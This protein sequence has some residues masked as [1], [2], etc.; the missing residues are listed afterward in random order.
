[1]GSKKNLCIIGSSTGGPRILRKMFADFPA[2]DCSIIL[3]QHM[4]KHINESFRDKLDSLT[5]MDVKLAEDNELLEHGV[6]YVAPSE[7]HLELLNNRRIKLRDGEKVNYVKPSVDVAMKSLSP[8]KLKDEDTLLG[9][10]LTGMGKDGAEG[11]EHMKE[12]GAETF[13]QDEKTSIMFRMPKSAIDTGMIDQVLEPDKIENKL[14][15]K[16]GKIDQ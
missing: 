6:L 10:I 4:V 9:I 11:I 14:I 1:M 8:S 5:A 12:L 15:D 7:R 13:A 2:L 3:V 16:F